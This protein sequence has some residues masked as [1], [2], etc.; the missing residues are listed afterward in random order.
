[1]RACSLASTWPTDVLDG[2]LI[3]LLTVS[4]LAWLHQ[5]AAARAG[6]PLDRAAVER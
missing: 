2:W 3:G 5:R 4:V 6:L 1:M